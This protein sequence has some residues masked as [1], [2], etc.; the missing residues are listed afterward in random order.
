[1]KS[2]EIRQKFLRFFENRGHSRVSSSSLI[3]AEDPTLLFVNAGMNQF[4][5]VF[6]GLDKRS[7]SR[8]ASSQKCVRAGGKHNDL[9]NV[10]HTSRHLTFF[11]MLGNYSFGDYFKKEAVKFAW[12]L[13]TRDFALPPDKLW[14]TVFREDDEAANLWSDHVGVAPERIARMDEK[15]D[16]RGWDLWLNGAGLSVHII[17]VWPTNALKVTTMAD[18]V[19]PGQWQHVLAT[20][21]GSGTPGGIRIYIDGT[22]APLKVDQGSL[23]ADATIRTKTP[24][25]I[26]QRSH[27]QVFAGGAIQDV[28]IFNR[29][30]TSLEARAIAE[31][32]PLQTI[33]A[34]AA[35]KRTPQQRAALEEHFLFTRDP[36]FSGLVKKISDLEAER[37]TIKSRGA[38]THIQMEKSNSPPLANRSARPHFW[39]WPRLWMSA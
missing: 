32:A 13:L 19:K 23:K 26:G 16:Y 11:E 28:R 34:T 15:A 39:P 35:E 4:K 37:Q 36:E 38:L 12:E 25:R 7:F 6:L 24:L 3:P 5:D 27:T 33:L 31:S 10:G 9:D 17:Q 1:M 2:V 22:S 14:I 20:Y 18:V 29:L 30:L 8:A 21:D